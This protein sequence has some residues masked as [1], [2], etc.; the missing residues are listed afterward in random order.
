MGYYTDFELGIKEGDIT[1][2]EFL[3]QHGDRPLPSGEKLNELFA[4]EGYPF[5]S[6]KWY[7]S[8][9]D[10]AYISKFE[11]DVVLYLEGK[12]EEFFDYWVAYFK[13]GKMHRVV[14]K[15]ECPPYDEKKL[16]QLL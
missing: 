16:T 3:E 10:M 7:D 13:N 2:A 15:M 5:D 12:G 11:P 1:I 4:D 9:T 8:D 6:Y 14:G